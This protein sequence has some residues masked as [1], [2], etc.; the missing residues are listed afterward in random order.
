MDGLKRGQQIEVAML[1]VVLGC[2]LLAGDAPHGARPGAGAAG[3][4]P[5]AGPGGASEVGV[6]LTGTDTSTVVVVAEDFEDG[7]GGWQALGS[8]TVQP[9]AVG[10][11]GGAALRVSDRTEPWH[12]AQLPATTLLQPGTD[13]TVSAWLRLEPGADPAELRLTVERRVDGVSEYDHLA[14]ATVTS[15]E[16]V[17]VTA[18][19]EMPAGADQ[20][21]LYVESTGSPA[22]FRLDDVTVTSQVTPVQTDIPALREVRADDFAVGV[23]VGPQDMVGAPAQ[24]L[25]RH[26]GSLTPENAMKTAVVQPRE[27]EFSFGAADQ[28]ADFAVRHGLAV[29]GHTFVWYRQTPDWF[30]L[31]GEG[32]PLTDS[33][34]HQALLLERLEAHMRAVAEHLEERYGRDNPVR[35]WDVVNEAIDPHEDDGLRRN[36]WYEVLGPEYLAHAFRL[37]D[38]VFG[39]DVVL[40]LNEYDTDFPDKRRATARVVERLLQDGVPIDG[41]GHQMHVALD[42]PVERIE[43]TFEAFARLGVEQAVT[44]LD[45]SISHVDEQLDHTPPERLIRQGE[46][47]AELLAVLR[48]HDL[49]TVSVWGL[50]DGRSW[51]RSWPTDRPHEAPLLFDDALRAKPAYWGLVDPGRVGVGS[52]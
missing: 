46:Y 26:F 34:D 24:L 7:S 47:L 29:H 35:S 4:D 38:E 18:R 21:R 8:A 36:Q 6:D 20:T 3:T 16:W 40:Y 32:R 5:A 1:A 25:L 50:Y 39:E 19:Y 42:R 51:L 13:Y 22:G 43:E 45:V 44:E 12:G 9:D 30:F 37:A 52:P 11:R 41:V 15:R 48:R 31:D 28:V 33:P 10:V 14:R 23:A 17:E 49:S 2:L 27:G